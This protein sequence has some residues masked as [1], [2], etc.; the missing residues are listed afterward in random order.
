MLACRSLLW[1]YET[2][3]TLASGVSVRESLEAVI[4]C[5]GWQPETFA[6]A[7]ESLFAPTSHCSELPGT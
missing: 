4:R 2:M 5:E 6:S 7:Q 3:C 1:L